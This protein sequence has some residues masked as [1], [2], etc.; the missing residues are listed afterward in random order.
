MG[1]TRTALSFEGKFV[2]IPNEWAR[3]PRISRRARGLLAEI[4]SHRIGWHVTTRSLT[5]AGVEGRD[6][7][8][9]MLAELVK[10]GYL[11]AAQQ[12]GDH[13]QF[14]EIEYV[15]SDP[16]DQDGK[17]VT[18]D[19]QLPL[20]DA[21]VTVAGFS[22]RGGSAGVGLAVAGS[23]VDGE[24]ATK[25]TR[26]KEHHQVE[27]KTPVLFSEFWLVYPRREGR[28]KA[29]TAFAKAVALVGAERVMAGARRF[30]NDPNLPEDKSFIP[31]PATWLNQKRWDDEPLPARHG[32]T[33][34]V[35]DFGNDE[36]MYRT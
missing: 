2:Q 19:L 1:I 16:F 29:E 23:A 20:N 13:G 5:Q 18:V 34:G 11:V 24:S 30:A 7:V 36:W 26:V 12:R 14:G 9:S 32:S 17:S 3:D 15:L 6:A 22:G 25:N 33:A 10:A 21:D 27:D 8:R 31:H 4:A 28:G 35:Q